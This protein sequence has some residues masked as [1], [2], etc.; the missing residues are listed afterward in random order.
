MKQV[1]RWFVL[2]VAAGCG[3]QSRQPGTCEK[4]SHCEGSQI[5]F[6]KKCM[7]VKERDKILQERQEA[8][9]PKVCQDQDGDGFRAGNGCLSGE[10]IDCDDKNP[11]IAPGKEELCDEVDNN[12]DGR[13]NEGMKGCVQTIFGGATWG[14][15]E[16]HRLDAPRG[17]VYDPAGFVV[18]SDNHH[19]WKVFLEDGR[20]E[21]LA[22][23]VVSN[24]Q[25]GRGAEARFAYPAGLARAEDGTIYVADCKNNCVRR[26]TPAGEVSVVA[27]LCSPLT[28][29]SGQFADGPVSAARFYCPSDVAVDRD[30]TLL[31]VDRENAR[32]RRIAGGEVTTLAG[33]GPV[34]VEEGEG[35]IGFQDGPAGEARFN[36]P[37]AVLFDARG[38]VVC[39]SFN[40]RLRRIAQVPG[41]GWMVSTLAGTSDT[42]LGVGGFQD[43][44]AAA[45]KFSYPHG[46]ISDGRGNILIADTGNAVI[47]M[48]TANG[49]VKTLYGKPGESKAVDGP[50]AGARFRTPADLAL[51]PGD[52]IFVVDTEANRVR[53]IVP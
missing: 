13:I 40:C 5:C 20:V 36:D 18:V 15:Q 26:V 7:T 52:S 11:A 25:D 53:W 12:C 42:K 37:Q 8:S 46:I 41:K 10:K 33:L 30:G 1:A 48:L 31:V 4:D 21:L 50:L 16:K 34:E 47:R 32:I 14:N 38:I 24:F 51:G 28:K 2:L 3:C 45:A 19:L 23:D 9:K 35:Q 29:N 6:E 22:G 43:G 44:P 49:Q 17:I 39:E 27:G